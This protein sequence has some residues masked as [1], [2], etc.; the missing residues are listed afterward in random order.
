VSERVNGYLAKGALSQD[1]EQ[2]KLGGVGLLRAFLHHISDVDLLDL[3][4]LLGEGDREGE[5]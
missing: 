1:L 2:L 3:R 5:R 4:F